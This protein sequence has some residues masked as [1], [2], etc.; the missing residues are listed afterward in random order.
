M[1]PASKTRN[2]NGASPGRI[3]EQRL[4]EVASNLRE[5]SSIPSQ[6]AAGLRDL[7]LGGQWRPGERVVEWKLARQLGIGQ[8]TAR[9]AL[10]MLEA[11]G[12]VQRNAN[13]GCRVTQLNMTEIKQ[14]YEVRVELEPLAAE[15]AVKNSAQWDPRLLTS[16]MNRLARSAQKADFV[17]W[18]LRDLEFHRTLWR[19]AGNPILEKALSQV[20]VPFFA[21]AELVFIQTRPRD[22]VRQAGQ[23]ELITSAILSGDARQARRVTRQVLRGF[24]AQWTSRGK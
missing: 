22:L 13:R 23:H 24:Q 14:I 4:S 19:L 18:H 1:F 7:I 12:L 16:A 17:E 10:L 9:E 5:A 20:S 21:F 15:L 2:E 6:V 3:I 11:E 8:P